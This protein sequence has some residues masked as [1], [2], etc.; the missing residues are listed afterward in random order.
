M[1]A[2]KGVGIIHCRQLII[3]MTIV[4]LSI[5]VEGNCMSVL[6]CFIGDVVCV[7]FGLG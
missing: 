5:A 6:S 1:L 2:H 7:I 4:G 3:V